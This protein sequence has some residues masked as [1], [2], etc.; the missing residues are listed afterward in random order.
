MNRVLSSI[1]THPLFNCHSERSSFQKIN[2]FKKSL[3]D[4]S[5]GLAE[6]VTV[7]CNDHQYELKCE[8][9]FYTN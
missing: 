3:N 2:E 9:I 5:G 8:Q 1:K 4:L 7:V 6:K